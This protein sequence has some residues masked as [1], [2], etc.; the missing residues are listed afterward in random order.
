MP[1][2]FIPSLVNKSPNMAQGLPQNPCLNPLGRD[3]VLCKS[4]ADDYRRL[5]RDIGDICA[6]FPLERYI[7]DISQGYCSNNREIS[8]IY[9]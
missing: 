5:S 4:N 9:R 1:L 6:T 7:G 3:T 2:S 8:Q